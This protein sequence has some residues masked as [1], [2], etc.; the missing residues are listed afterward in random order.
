MSE[1]ENSEFL[2]ATES[3]RPLPTDW[4]EAHVTRRDIGRFILKLQLTNGDAVFCLGGKITRGVRGHILC[5]VVDNTPASVR[6]EEHKNVYRALE[7]R[8]NSDEPIPR[9]RETVVIRSWCEGRTIGNGIRPCGCPI[10]V[11]SSGRYGSFAEFA[12]GDLVEVEI[13]RSD[14]KPGL[15]SARV[16]AK[17]EKE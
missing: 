2:Q 15:A 10:F 9:T 12:E 13:E 16:I 8:F 11:T 1:A 3:W 5:S 14:R 6:I 7:C 17:G 4:Y